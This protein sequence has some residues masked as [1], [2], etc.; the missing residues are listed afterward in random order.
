MTRLSTICVFACLAV[1]EARRSFTDMPV[2][3]QARQLLNLNSILGNPTSAQPYDRILGSPVFQ[4]TTAWGSPYMNMEKLTE[5]DGSGADGSGLFQKDAGS[6]KSI[7]EEQNEYRTV[8]LFFMDPDDALGVHAELKQ[9]EQMKKSD[10]RI[11]SNSLGKALRAAANLGNGL[12]TGYPIEPLNGNLKPV[13]EGGSLRHKIMPDKRQLFY[14]A[15]CI[16][17]ERVGLFGD[18]PSELATMALLGNSAIE[19]TNLMRRRDKRE[20]KT[21][22]PP[23]SLLEAQNAHM[24]GYVGIP[25]FHA[26]GMARKIP[27]LKQISSGNRQETPM[28]FNYED[29]QDAWTKMKKKNPSM[30]D[31][32]TVEVFNLFDVLTSMDKDQWKKRKEAGKF[33]IMAPLRQRFGKLEGP[34][35]DSITFVPSSRAIDYKE[36]LSARGNGK[37][38]L[39]P[40]R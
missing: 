7:S 32:P 16:G 5:M 19:A 35:L 12:P 15:R 2:I 6:L 18:N 9:M 29:L 26:S 37:A 4:V 3:K 31:K 20:R 22:P 10:I 39:R 24:D 23:K 13:E 14:A 25:V 33:D 34:D 21:T 28:F 30:P 36:K 27:K 1:I 17:K 11:T 38:R 8:T 40:M